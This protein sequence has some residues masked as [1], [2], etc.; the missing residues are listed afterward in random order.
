[1][2]TR[3]PKTWLAAILSTLIVCGTSVRAA[4]TTIDT[5]T[6]SSTKFTLSNGDSFTV[7]NG[8]TYD[9]STAA[10]LEI[11]NG[12]ITVTEGSTFLGG[13]NNFWFYD[14]TVNVE[15][16]SKMEVCTYD[17]GSQKGRCYIGNLF[18]VS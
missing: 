11:V 3:L 15:D 16:S 18:A 14:G 17:A 6:E 4:G 13:N 7:T 5:N 8:A 2:K 10:T 12:D 9:M 1:M